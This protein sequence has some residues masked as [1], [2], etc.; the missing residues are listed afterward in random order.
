MRKHIFKETDKDLAFEILERA[1]YGHLAFLSEGAPVSLPL[2][3]VL[4]GEALFFHGAQE[5]AVGKL[6]GEPVCLTAQDMCAWVPSTWRH[7]KNACPATTFYR[8]VSVHGVLEA[9]TD[10][11]LK[12]AVLERFMTKYQP[13]GGHEPIGAGAPRY[14]GVLESLA[15]SKLSLNRWDAKVKMG[16]NLSRGKQKRIYDGF[17]QR[18]NGDD[19]WAA[20]EM[21][22]LYPHLSAR[23]SDNGLVW[24][25]DPRA[26][27]L[28]PLWKMISESYWAEGREP[29]EVA[30]HLEESLLVLGG[31]KGKELV[32]FGRLASTGGEAAFLFDVVVH[33]E[34]RGRGY[35]QALM[36]RL[37]SHPALASI[38]R[39]Y[40][41]TRD[42]S[43]FY[44]KFG[45]RPVGQV[46]DNVL[47][48]LGTEG[49]EK[50]H[51][52]T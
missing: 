42:A 21:A 36:R 24:R 11:E 49:V 27:P 9:V 26:I 35:G 46:S 48:V 34:I 20:L 31:F 40:L 44:E 10:V 43:S 5:A 4:L 22:R 33:P 1:R 51:H 52:G 30:R 3:F 2:N 14:A 39:I 38:S 41:H 45:F 29:F 50:S 18:Q 37:L 6:V 13:E 7:P 28:K 32:A 15:V 19:R 12:G 8:S 23:E 25:D 17:L 47:M 16:Q